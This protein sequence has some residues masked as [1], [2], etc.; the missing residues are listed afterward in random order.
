MFLKH[1]SVIGTARA[2]SRWHRALAHSRCAVCVRGLVH[3]YEN[4]LSENRIARVKQPNVSSW[5]ALVIYVKIYDTYLSHELCP[6]PHSLY[7]CM[8][9]HLVASTTGLRAYTINIV[10]LGRD[11]TISYASPRRPFALAGTRLGDRRLWKRCHD[12]SMYRCSTRDR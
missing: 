8:A 12:R 9:I 10:R 2:R 11:I 1:P 6:R 7:G 3:V 5:P 4:S